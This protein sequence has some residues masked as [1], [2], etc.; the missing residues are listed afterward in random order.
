MADQKT[1]DEIKKELLD[2]FNVGVESFKDQFDAI[3]QAS[4]ELLGTFT[5]GRQRIG[6]LRTALADALPDVTRRS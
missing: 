1:F 3:A 4:N 2:S 6:E 5:Q